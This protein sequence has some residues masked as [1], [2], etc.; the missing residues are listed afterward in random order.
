MKPLNSVLS[1]Y[2]TTIFTVMSALASQH[3]AVNLGQGFPDD[4]GPE[5]IRRCAAET[6]LQGPNQ[7]PLMRGLAE[8]RQ[9]VAEHDRRFYGLDVDW[10]TKVLVTSGATEA[11]ADCF[12][13]LLEPGDEV[14]LLEPLYDSYLPIIERAGAVPCLSGWSRRS[15]GCRGGRSKPRSRRKRSCWCSTRRST[16]SARSS[17]KRS[18]RS[19]R[20]CSKRRGCPGR[21]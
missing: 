19:S 10:Q 3:G 13:G 1:R 18:Y 14:V 2:G 17:T 16:P 20:V 8:L 4:E 12:F 11:L 5:S 21:C 15:G 6:V 7:Y 9:A